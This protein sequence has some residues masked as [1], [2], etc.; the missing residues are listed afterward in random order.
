MAHFNFQFSDCTVKSG[1]MKVFKT[2]G[3]IYRV[4]VNIDGTLT[5]FREYFSTK[6]MPYWAK[7]GRQYNKTDLLIDEQGGIESLLSKCEDIDDIDNYIHDLNVEKRA[8]RERASQER[9]RQME[10]KMAKS[11]ADYERVFEGKDVVESTAESIYILLA[12]LNTQNW[13]GWRLP[14]MTIGYSCH[15]Y[16]CDG[17]TATTIMLDQPVKVA[18]RMGTMFEY[19]APRGHL[20]KYQPIVDWE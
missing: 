14:K 10:S 3:V 12:Y 8:I 17:K 19:G 4:E 16:D 11:K 1:T 9:A 6:K 18:G 15:Q 20:T 13:G 7:D 2:T 5:I